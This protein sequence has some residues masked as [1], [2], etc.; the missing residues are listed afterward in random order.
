MPAPADHKRRFVA[1]IRAGKYDLGDASRVAGLT[2]SQ[3]AEVWADGVAAGRLRIADDLPG[4][5]Y[6]EEIARK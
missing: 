3:G 5:R 6:I 1:A 4:F 2:F